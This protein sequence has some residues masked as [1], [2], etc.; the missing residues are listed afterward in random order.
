VAILL[1]TS[2]N[3]LL[4]AAYAVAYSGGNRL[5]WPVSALAVLAACGG[6]VAAV[7]ALG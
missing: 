1:A 5:L 4:K 6:G 2:S 7:L 3:N